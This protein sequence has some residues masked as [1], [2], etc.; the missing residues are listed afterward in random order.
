MAALGTGSRSRCTSF[1]FQMAH[2]LS[3]HLWNAAFLVV[4]ASVAL[5][6][7]RIAAPPARTAA[8]V[9]GDADV[10]DITS[11]VVP[12]T[13]DSILPRFHMTVTVDPFDS[14][15]FAGERSA[16]ASAYAV[17]TVPT[18]SAAPRL[19]AILIAD[20]RRVAVVDDAMVS[21]GDVLR[22]GARVSAIQP[23]RVFVV[24]KSGRWRTLTLTNRGTR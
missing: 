22:D 3:G 1:S 23:D 16:V 2:P 12:A 14:R 13:T 9:A 5:A 6:A 10:A 4:S 17:P 21:V 11:F 18:A 15:W 8:S 20:E 19:T 24:E 7:E